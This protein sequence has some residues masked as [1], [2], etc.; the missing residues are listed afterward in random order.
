MTLEPDGTATGCNPVEVGST[1]TGVSDRPTAGSDY[2]SVNV[3]RLN[4]SFVG[5]SQYK[6][7]C[8]LGVHDG[9]KVAMPGDRLVNGAGVS[10]EMKGPVNNRRL[11]CRYGRP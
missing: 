8:L 10:S 7:N 5:R 4:H 11:R 6:P 9:P 2:I 3:K 1:P